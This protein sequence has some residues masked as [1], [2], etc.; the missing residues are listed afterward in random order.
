MNGIDMV[1]VRIEI[2][3]KLIVGV[4]SQG[5]KYAI[6]NNGTIVSSGGT[7]GYCVLS[8]PSEL[9]YSIYYIQAILGSIQGEWL[10]SLYGE[11]FRG[12]FISRGTKVLEQIPVRTIDFS[13][14]EEKN[15]H[16]D[17]VDRQKKLISLGDKISKAS[18]NKRKLTPLQRR[19]ANLKREQQNAI[20]ALYGMTEEEALLIPIIKE[21]YAA[22]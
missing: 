4:M 17:I 9:H 5:D 3:Q 12:G 13:N 8:I 15:M 19:F 6:D 22:D 11:I 1:G 2:K 18:G 14:T 21:Q 10:A 20:N 7:A 16:D